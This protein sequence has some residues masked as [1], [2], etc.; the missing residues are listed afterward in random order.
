METFTH[1]KKFNISFQITISTLRIFY[2]EG[3]ATYLKLIDLNFSRNIVLKDFCFDKVT[4]LFIVIKLLVQ[5]HFSLSCMKA[6]R[7]N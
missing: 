1:S 6:G 7:T 4:C 2:L 3:L 5:I